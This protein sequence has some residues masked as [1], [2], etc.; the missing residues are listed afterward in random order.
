MPMA[1]IAYVKHAELLL[2]IF[3]VDANRA[4]QAR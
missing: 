3:L 1:S 4:M 2:S